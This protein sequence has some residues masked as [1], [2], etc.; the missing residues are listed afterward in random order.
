MNWGFPEN[1]S[2]FGAS[3]DATYTAILVATGIAFLLVQGLLLY[4]IV[5]FRRRPGRRAIPIHGNTKLEVVW[6]VIPALGVFIIA[7]L[8]TSVWL[9]IKHPDRFPGDNMTL[10]IHAQQFEWIVTYPGPDGELGTGDDFVLRNQLHIPV[11]RAVRVILTA[12]DVI[13]SFFLP[14]FR[15]KQDAVPGMEIPIWFQATRTGEFDLGC[16]ELCGLGHYRMRG[17]VTVH[18]P[19]GFDA[20]HEEEAALASRS[21]ADPTTVAAR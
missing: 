4:S 19:E 6:T 9:D 18:T 1:V 7:F 12:E 15:V 5:R 20:W 21:A 3:I 13:H 16:A 2:T 10:A 8:S 14:H 17:M 11:D